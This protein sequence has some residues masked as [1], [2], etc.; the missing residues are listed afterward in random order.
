MRLGMLTPSSNTVLEPM[1][2][3]MLAGTAHSAHFARLRVLSIGL[4]ATENAQFSHAPM[5]DAAALLADARVHSLCW[6]GTSGAWLGLDADRALAAACTAATGIPVTTCTLALMQALEILGAKR[7]ALVTPY[8][9]SV[10]QAIM[11]NLARESLDC[12]A[13]RHLEDPGNYSFA[14]HSEARVEELVRQVAT[15]EGRHRPEAIII[16]CTNFRGT[17]LA[18]RLEAELD[19]VILDS[20][21]VALWGGLR[22]AGQPTTDL[23]AWGRLFAI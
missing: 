11:A 18:A 7:V 21:A 9:A 4:D 23:A 17:R 13:E 1:T 6:N 15:A 3:L 19:V 12:V 16:H 2:A 8:L 14:D 5:L 10:Q 20:I 22:A